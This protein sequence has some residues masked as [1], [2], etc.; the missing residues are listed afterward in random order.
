MRV[1]TRLVRRLYACW[2]EHTVRQDLAELWERTREG[3]ASDAWACHLI[4]DINKRLDKA[5]GLRLA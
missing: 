5:D 4:A 3:T 2:V 1:V